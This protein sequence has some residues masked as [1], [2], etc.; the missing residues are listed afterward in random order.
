MKTLLLLLLFPVTVFA[1]QTDAEKD[2]VEEG[3][4]LYRS[5]MA[6]WH[7]TDLFLEQF[8]HHRA[9]IGGYF[10]Y[11]DGE[12]TR[13]V[14]YDKQAEPEI[15]AAIAFDQTFDIKTAAV[16]STRKAFSETETTLYAIRQAALAEIRNDT[17]FK[18]YSNT[19]LNIIPLV[20]KSERKVYVLTGPQV[21]G[22]VIFG[23]DY[24]LT[25]D[26]EN[27]VSGKKMLHANIIPIEYDEDAKN[28]QTVMH[29]HL[30]ATGDLITATDICT[31]ML[32]EKYAGWESHIVVS[33]K[34]VNIWTCET[35]SLAVIP[36]DDFEKIAKDQEKRSKKKK[37]N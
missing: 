26:D 10:S 9:N 7:G 28:G 8:A 1:Q 6:S 34:F 25:F 31:L 11:P 14:F 2:V 12:L 20:W 36:R 27:R 3:R 18:S 23:N 32:Y 4:A 21:T 29:S 13:C 5:E 16:D 24:L 15:L 30:P 17:L 22:V 37:K 19:S 33:E 35:N